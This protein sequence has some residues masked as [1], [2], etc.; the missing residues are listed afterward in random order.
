MYIK[1]NN[2][3]V[4]KYPYTISDL[5]NDYPNTSFPDKLSTS[6]LNELSLSEIVL[7]PQPEITFKQNI[8]EGTPV[9]EDG[10]WKQTWIIS[11]KPIE[12]IESIVTNLRLSDY[13]K[14]SDPLF[15]KWQRGEATEQEWLDKV[16]EI[17]QRWS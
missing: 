5:I 4:E 13:R 6:L 9:N 16:N 1:I 14:E 2:G 7:T 17:K 12:E 10:V 15:F 8:I 11:D 3:V